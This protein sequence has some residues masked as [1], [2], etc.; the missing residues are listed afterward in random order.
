[1]AQWLR[2]LVALPEVLSSILSNHMVVHNHL[3]QD[4]MPS[5]G[6]NVY[7]QIEQVMKTETP[8][9]LYFIVFECLEMVDDEFGHHRSEHHSTS[10]EKLLLTIDGN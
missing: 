7:M 2:A 1:M 6:I 9:L 4:L 10:S 3:Q 8:H 5:S